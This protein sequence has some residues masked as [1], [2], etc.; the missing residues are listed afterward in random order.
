MKTKT[1]RGHARGLWAWPE[2]FL[3]SQL[4]SPLPLVTHSTGLESY[5]T[6]TSVCKP[7][8]AE[9]SRPPGALPASAGS[10]THGAIRLEATSLES[11]PCPA[12]TVSSRRLGV[13]AQHDSHLPILTSA[14]PP[15]VLARSVLLAHQA[16]GRAPLACAQFMNE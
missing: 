4:C 10:Y 16:L 15:L 6:G 5:P 14:S 1:L 7:R 2:A 9:V 8:D 12:R 13:L 11:T 3:P